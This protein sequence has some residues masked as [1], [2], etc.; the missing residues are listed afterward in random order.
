MEILNHLATLSVG[1]R[2][3]MPLITLLLGIATIA[4]AV[5]VGGATIIVSILLAR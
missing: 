5:V 3:H 4:A 2:P 1:L